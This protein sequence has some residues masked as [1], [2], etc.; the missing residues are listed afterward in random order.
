MSRH[1]LTVA[2]GALLRS[3]SC[4]GPRRRARTPPCPAVPR[5]RP[6]PPGGGTGPRLALAVLGT[7]L[8]AAAPALLL[9]GY[10][11]RLFGPDPVCARD[12]VTFGWWFTAGTAAMVVIT[13]TG[14]VITARRDASSVRARGERVSYGEAER[15]RDAR[16]EALLERG[17]LPF[18]REAL[19]EPGPAAEQ[20]RTARSPSPGAA[21]GQ[22]GRRIGVPSDPAGRK[23]P[24]VTDPARG[25]VGGR[26][27]GDGRIACR[28]VRAPQPPSAVRGRGPS[29]AAS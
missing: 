29:P 14:M 24:R 4:T 21:A 18:L 8:G 22:R 19:A 12:P 13:T 26:P 5:T 2:V 16:R 17:V 11:L 9:V 23:R 15:A 1:R 10:A 27:V 28:C 7:L 6:S 3:G 20:P 25:T